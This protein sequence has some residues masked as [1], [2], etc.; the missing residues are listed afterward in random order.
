[1]QFSNLWLDLV[2]D[3][4]LYTNFKL[5]NLRQFLQTLL[6]NTVQSWRQ[7]HTKTAAVQPLNTKHENYPNL[8]DKTCWRS[9]GELISNVFQ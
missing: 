2:S 6:R 8:T 5:V 1:M 9:K 7:H 3:K 4:C